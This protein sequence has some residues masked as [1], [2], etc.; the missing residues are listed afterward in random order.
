MYIQKAIVDKLGIDPSKIRTQDQFYDLLVQIK[1]GDFKDDNGNPVYPLGPKY[2]GGSPDTL[3]YIVPGFTWGVSDGYNLDSN[4]V[5][6]HEADTDYVFEKNQLLKKTA[7][8]RPD[9]SGVLHH[10]WNQSGRSVQ[11]S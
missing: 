6:K 9:E 4:G 2:W 10:G 7:G 3:Q 1:N 5:I 8:R 11:I